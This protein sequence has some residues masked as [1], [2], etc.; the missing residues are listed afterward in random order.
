MINQN[1]TRTRTRT[2]SRPGRLSLAMIAIL[3]A[4]AI[5]LPMLIGSGSGRDRYVRPLSGSSFVL[6]N[7]QIIAFENSV[8]RFDATTGEIATLHG[9][10]DNP[11]AQKV[12]DLKVRKVSGRTSGL[13]ELQQAAGRTFLVDVVDGRTWLLNRRGTNATWDEIRTI[14]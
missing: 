9:N 10:L 4:A 2:R 13:L 12:W 5:G 11:S 3:V 14:R 8:A 7:V 1:R 6:S